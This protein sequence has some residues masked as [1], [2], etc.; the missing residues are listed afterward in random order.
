[1]WLYVQI[2]GGI[3]GALRLRLFVVECAN[4]NRPGKAGNRGQSRRRK[5]AGVLLEAPAFFVCAWR[6]VESTVRH[7]RIMPCEVGQ[8]VFE[9][10]GELCSQFQPAPLVNAVLATDAPHSRQLPVGRTRCAIE[11]VTG[12]GALD[13]GFLFAVERVLT[14][15]IREFGEIEV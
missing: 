3:A 8:I 14:A 15:V 2:L 13:H 11:S 5:K 6:D 1:M 4:T 9:L 7:L 12:P 10:F